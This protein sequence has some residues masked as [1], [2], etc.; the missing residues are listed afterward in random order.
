MTQRERERERE[1]EGERERERERERGRE[2]ER[3]RERERELRGLFIMSRLFCWLSVSWSADVYT[4]AGM[5]CP[6]FEFKVVTNG[7]VFVYKRTYN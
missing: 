4:Q 6:S 2:K 7:F 1:R 3:E 5:G